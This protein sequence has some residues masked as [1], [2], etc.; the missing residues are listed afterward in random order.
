MISTS[1]RTSCRENPMFLHVLQGKT[2]RKPRSAM[3][4][5]KES[6]VL[7]DDLQ[8]VFQTLAGRLLAFFF[9]QEVMSMEPPPALKGIDLAL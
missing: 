7:Q 2:K 1:S 8:N 4:S 3:F 6:H 9:F 5:F